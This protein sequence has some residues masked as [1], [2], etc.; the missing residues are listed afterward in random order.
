MHQSLRKPAD[1]K[2][3][4]HPCCR[5]HLQAERNRQMENIN[6]NIAEQNRKEIE[7]AKEA[8]R[9]V[10]KRSITGALVFAAL[11]AVYFLLL[12]YWRQSLRLSGN[13]SFNLAIFPLFIFVFG[14]TGN[15]RNLI[16]CRR[17]TR[18]LRIREMELNTEEQRKE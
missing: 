9:Q 3:A 7:L 13:A 14:C 1:N 6:T 11:A 10:R 15:L 5:F 2:S 8:V 17:I 16:N 12:M 4:K 18:S